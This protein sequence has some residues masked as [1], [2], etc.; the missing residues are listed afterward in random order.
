MKKI[1]FLL[2]VSA[3][4]LA[5]CRPSCESLCD[6]PCNGATVAECKAS[7]IKLDGLNKTSDCEAKYDEML[8]CLG[9][10]EDS[11]RC[12]TDNTLCGGE[13]STYSACVFG[14]CTAH[15]TDPE[16]T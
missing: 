7:C 5:S 1:I 2:G 10:L 12:S 8:S 9:G 4:M 16:C 13:A 14:Y 6:K 11:V 3:L 15:P